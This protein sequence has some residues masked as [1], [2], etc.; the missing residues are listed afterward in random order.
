MSTKFHFD[1]DDDEYEP[2]PEGTAL[3]SIDHGRCETIKLVSEPLVNGKGNTLLTGGS[4]RMWVTDR[5][6]I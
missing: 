5:R 3:V 1:T 6:A 4:L 2:D